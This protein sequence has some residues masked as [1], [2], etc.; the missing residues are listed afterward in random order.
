MLQVDK[1][2]KKG[3]CVVVGWEGLCRSP[4]PA[5][6]RPW[7]TPPRV[8]VTLL[9][10]LGHLWELWLPLLQKIRGSKT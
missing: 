6:P 10:L 9:V 7:V 1:L 8:R 2:L 3:S 4:L 5:E